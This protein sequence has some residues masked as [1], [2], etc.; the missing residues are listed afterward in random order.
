MLCIKNL[1]GIA[2]PPPRRTML[3]SLWMFI[4]F[5]YSFSQIPSINYKDY[6]HLKIAAKNS[7]S[8]EKSQADIVCDGTRDQEQINDALKQKRLVKLFS[9][10]FYI[11]APIIGKNNILIGEGQN[12]IIQMASG[13]DEGISIGGSQSLLEY[14]NSVSAGSSSMITK[15]DHSGRLKAG[16]IVC[17][18]SEDVYNGLRGYY[19][20]GEMLTIK[21]IQGNSITFTSPTKNKYTQSPRLI[22]YNFADGAGIAD[23]KII[24]G[25][26]RSKMCNLHETKNGFY[27]NVHL[28]GK[29]VAKQGLIASHSYN[30][31]FQNCVA[32]NVRDYDAASAPHGY[33]YYLFGVVKGK[34]LDC[35]GN[36]NKHSVELGGYMYVPV[37]EQIEINNFDA[38]NDY[39]E[40]FSTHGAA[41]DNYWIDCSSI[42]SGG[43]FLLRSG[44]NEIIRPVVKTNRVCSYAFRFGEYTQQGGTWNKYDGNGGKDLI[45]DGAV[46]ELSG[47]GNNFFFYFTDPAIN[48]KITNGNFKGNR[49]EVFY[50][51]GLE[52]KN[53]EISN[54]LFDVSRQSSE[55]TIVKIEPGGGSPTIS[56]S[57]KNISFCG[58]RNQTL[59]YNSKGGGLAKENITYDCNAP[60]QPDE[61][62]AT[63]TIKVIEGNLDFCPGENVKLGAPS[64]YSSYLW[65]NGETTQNITVNETGIYSVIVKNS[66]G[67]ASDKSNELSVTLHSTPDSPVIEYS[68]SLNR[69]AGDS[70]IL[71]VP[72]GFKEYQWS[73]GTF[74]DHIVVKN[75]GQYSVKVRNDA[76][77]WSKYSVALDVSFSEE[78]AAPSITSNDGLSLCPGNKITLSAPDGFTAYKWNNGKSTRNI[79]VTEAGAFS[80]QVNNGACWSAESAK[81]NISSETIPAPN[82]T[83][84][85]GLV[86]C[87]GEKTTLSA[88]ANYANYEW[89]NGSTSQRI[90]VNS[91]GT[92]RVRVKQNSCWSAFSE[93]TEVTSA[94][95][96]PTPEITSESGYSLCSGDQIMLSAPEGFGAYEWSNGSTTQNISVKEAGT[97][98]VRVKQ[99]SCWS[100]LSETVEVTGTDK[101][102]APEITSGSGY[103]L[104]SGDQITLSAP[105]GFSAYEWSNGSTTKNISV[106]EAGIFT[107]RVKQSSCWSEAS[108]PAEIIASEQLP[109]PEISSDAGLSLCGVEEL[110]L[111]APAGYSEYRWNNGSTSEKLVVNTPGTYSVQVKS[112]SCWSAE[113]K[114]VT[115]TEEGELVAPEITSSAGLIICQEEQTILS[116]PIG[117]NS[118]EWS[119]GSTTQKIVVKSTGSYSVRVNNSSCWSQESEPISIKVEKVPVPSISSNNG[120]TLCPGEEI[121]LSAPNGHQAYEWSN[122]STQQNIEVNASGSFDVR[123]KSK[124]GCWSDHSYVIKI[125]EDE[126]PPKPEITFAGNTEFCVGGTLEMSI[127]QS[128]EVYLWSNDETTNSISVD[129]SGS[130]S[131]KYKELNG[132]WSDFS[133]SIEVTV[134]DLP[135]KP[136]LNYSGEV[137]ICPGSELELYETNQKPMEWSN[138]YSGSLLT[139]SNPGVYS[140]VY[141]D[142]NGC[143]SQSSDPVTLKHTNLKVTPEVKVIGETSL[144]DGETVTLEV[145]GQYEN[146]YWNTGEYTKDISVDKPGFYEARVNVCEEQWSY[147]SMPVEIKVNDS[148]DAPDVFLVGDTIYA[149]GSA[150]SYSLLMDGSLLAESTDPYF[151]IEKEGYYSIEAG[152]DNCTSRSE[153]VF[154]DGITKDIVLTYPNPSSGIFNVEIVNASSS[155]YEFV[156]YNTINDVVYSKR[157]NSDSIQ[158]FSTEVNISDRRKGMYI[159]KVLFEDKVVNEKLI[160]N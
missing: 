17:L 140:A 21:S 108:A 43:G 113:S 7:T 25:S 136:T 129:N 51:N 100:E 160:I 101:L 42:N 53:L 10:T 37:T 90:E 24:N 54:C 123:V 33:G 158:D 12:T 88:P 125:T 131:V 142:E 154:Y 45:V 27:K 120:F 4:S 63:P 49:S 65:S 55:G 143:K 112:N 72:A 109:A 91:A 128:G 15:N 34:L 85:N 110:I 98:H 145:L 31:T 73:N 57:L 61:N 124:S 67:T 138:G 96:L 102:P 13:L 139:L 137:T 75:T 81:V 92:F 32:N 71:S 48:V 11:D 153:E 76:S 44:K 36:N 5:Y 3:L 22:K 8:T 46:V 94:V 64:G 135:G 9:G 149:D 80:V 150:S 29:L 117:Y 157:Y 50:S 93:I 6:P 89:N 156:V 86:L 119:D 82:I 87:P 23:L 2:M 60:E 151:K 52:C 14:P 78:I 16:D 68:G 20:N 141:I 99:N 130:Y 28:D 104:C 39:Y 83:N 118:Y 58:Y 1:Q 40:S 148:P 70:I 121:I 116:A 155:Q 69:C 26:K 133:N 127:V 59:I 105:E 152:N 97:F 18:T 114:S 47:S 159:L 30:L 144:C 84:N 35:K 62:I 122:G 132:C 66:S 95:D 111:S 134:Q 146:Y 126:K 74:E 56:G 41:Y 107:V 147:Y 19:W 103:S 106:K 115:V 79:E 77:C 38:V